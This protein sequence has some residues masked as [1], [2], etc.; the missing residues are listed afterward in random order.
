MAYDVQTCYAVKC[1]EYSNQKQ[2]ENVE[3]YVDW[4]FSL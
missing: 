2:L 1:V 3:K 4:A